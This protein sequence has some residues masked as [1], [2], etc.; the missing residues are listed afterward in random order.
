MNRIKLD[1]TENFLAA[2][3]KFRRDGDSGYS[4]SECLPDSE[5]F[6][7]VLIERNDLFADFFLAVLADEEKDGRIFDKLYG[8][9]VRARQCI[10]DIYRARGRERATGLFKQLM[11]LMYVIQIN[12]T[13]FRYLERVNFEITSVCNLRCSFCSFVSGKRK[14]YLEPELYRNILIE[15]AQKVPKLKKL[16]L[17]MSGESLL[18]PDFLKILEITA[19]VKS[20]Y[21]CFRPM[22]YLHT[23]GMLWTPEMHDKI[24]ATGAL[25]QA[26][27]SI[28][29]YDKESFERMRRGAK[30]DKVLSS[31]EYFLKNRN[32]VKGFVNNLIEPADIGKKRCDRLEKVL[33]QSDNVLM[34][35]PKDLSEES[36]EKAD[37]KWVGDSDS[38]CEYIFHTVI[39]N[40]EGRMSLCC[41]DLNSVNAFGNIAEE[42]FAAVYYGAERNEILRKMYLDKRK[43]I[44]GCKTCSLMTNEWSTEVVKSWL[45]SY[46]RG[47]LDRYIR[48]KGIKR[49]AIFAAGQHSIWM[50][51]VLTEEHKRAVVAVLDDNPEGK[52][53]FFGLQPVDAKT[54]DAKE[55]DGIV[56]SSDFIYDKLSD[57]CRELYGDD[58]CLINIYEGLPPGPYSK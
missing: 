3:E 28:D 47:T 6:L 5:T 14:K 23:N 44:K 54:F 27:W 15:L 8:F 52:G 57:R 50:E 33:M 49:L 24:I 43:E 21:P 19:E 32:G 11:K 37:T 22:T 39:V 55:I 10:R 18:H 41:L 51:R 1:T 29:G 30:Y 46:V 2:A 7:S 36:P 34:I 35:E 4:L 42:G 56:I 9:C 40:T 17:Y 16:A 45:A 12:T 38:F 53:T 31:Y 26:T 58:I 20:A 48:E 25:E 13:D